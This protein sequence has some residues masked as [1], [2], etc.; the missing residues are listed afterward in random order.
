MKTVCGS[1]FLEGRNKVGVVEDPGWKGGRERDAAMDDRSDVSNNS[2]VIAD[3]VVVHRGGLLERGSDADAVI[4][5]TMVVGVDPVN[6]SSSGR[7]GVGRG[8]GEGRKPGEFR[9]IELGQEG[10]V[11]KPRG[12]KGVGGFVAL[13]VGGVPITGVVDD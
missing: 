9:L 8:I 1:N 7:F 11:E 2:V 12:M 3:V 4:F 6:S 10:E 13:V 5:V